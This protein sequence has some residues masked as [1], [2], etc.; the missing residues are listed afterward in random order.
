MLIALV[1]AAEKS[2]AEEGRDII[3]G[4]LLT[5][6]IFVGVIAIGELS[7]WVRRRRGAAH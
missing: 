4:M 2:T 3:I 1:L 7:R 6:L 5:G